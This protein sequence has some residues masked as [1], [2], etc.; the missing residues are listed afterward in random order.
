MQLRKLDNCRWEVP[1]TGKMRVPGLIYASEAMINRAIGEKA[2]EQ[3]ANVACL[4]GIVGKSIAMPDIHW[5]YGFPIGGVAAFDADE[6]VVSPGGIGYDINCGVRLLRTNLT[7]KE[8]AKEIPRLIEALFAAVPSGVGSTGKLNL[9]RDEVMQVLE[10]GSRWAVKRGFGDASDLERTEEEGCLKGADASAASGRAVE[11]GR[12]QLGT[13]GAGN[14]FLELQEV[15]TIYDKVAAETFGLFEGQLTVMIHT[16]SRGLGYQVCDDYLV[17]LQEASRRYGI[18]L[19]DRQ[20]ACA[21][22]GSPEGRKYFSAMAGAANYAWANRQIITHWTR[23]TLMRA[24][25]KT[26]SELGLEVVYDVAHNIGKFEEHGGRK[27]IVH[28]KG[29]TR[30]FPP[31]SADIPAEYKS[32]GQPVLIPGTM[33]TESYVMAGTA[34][35]LKETWGSACHGAGRVMS[36][37]QALKGPRGQELTEELRKKGITVRADSMKTLAEEAPSAYKNVS[38]VVDICSEAG[39]S[40]KVAKLKPKGVIKG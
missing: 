38:E 25:G 30:A 27:L 2:A 33:G 14:H 29:A 1:K 21:P 19:P 15:E 10:N 4:P 16:G 31:G 7:Y 37:T 11:R 13:L 36:R 17:K 35:A 8:A 32:A 39:I 34:E 40:S 28:R 12:E 23:E 18:E 22:A 26:P 6:G 9:S 3:V 24:L 20:L 5:G